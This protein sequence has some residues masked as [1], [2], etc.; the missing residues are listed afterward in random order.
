[1]LSLYYL[2]IHIILSLMMY[3]MLNLMV[4]L[5]W[6]IVMF[7]K[8]RKIKKVKK[9]VNILFETRCF[10]I[11]FK[12]NY[13]YKFICYHVWDFLN[14]I[15]N[16]WKFTTTSSLCKRNHEC[17]NLLPHFIITCVVGP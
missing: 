9:I 4:L 3:G 11:F 1:L 5:L 13:Y 7:L 6:K 14:Q 15:E 16:K 2:S 8:K 12:T 10:Q 17:Q